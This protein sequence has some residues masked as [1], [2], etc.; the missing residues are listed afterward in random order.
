MNGHKNLGLKEKES[1]KN[2]WDEKASLPQQLEGLALA[3]IARTYSAS[4]IRWHW[5]ILVHLMPHLSHFLG[6][7]LILKV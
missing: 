2:K 1:Q 7:V 3:Q 5:L 6:A 4:K